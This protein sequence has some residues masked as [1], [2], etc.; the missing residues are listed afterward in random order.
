MA[1]IEAQFPAVLTLKPTEVEVVKP[2]AM[3]VPSTVAKWTS[4]S[5]EILRQGSVKLESCR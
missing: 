5:W 3:G 2:V 1:E 4:G